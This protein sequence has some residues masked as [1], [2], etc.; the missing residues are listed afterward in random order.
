MIAVRS[1]WIGVTT[2]A[3]AKLR[4]S[5]LSLEDLCG[6][7]VGVGD[8][9]YTVGAAMSFVEVIAS[10]VLLYQLERTPKI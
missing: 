2:S 3:A 9:S 1:T 7:A 10:N 5:V 4:V 8:G 6:G